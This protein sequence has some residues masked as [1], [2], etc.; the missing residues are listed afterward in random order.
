[1]GV[2]GVIITLIENIKAL[3]VGRAF[4]GISHGLVL[5][6]I[7][8]YVEETSPSNYYNTLASIFVI[9]SSF[10]AFLAQISDIVFTKQ[11]KFIFGFSVLFLVAIL[12]CLL[13][14]VKYDT[15]KFYLTKEHLIENKAP[16][17]V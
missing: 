8:R 16:L 12:V 4:T 17:M 1:M 9:S 15:P 14:C 11:W 3:M 7:R 5:I 13:F 6:S 2:I 10:G